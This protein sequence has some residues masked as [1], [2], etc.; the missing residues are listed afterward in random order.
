MTE[1]NTRDGDAERAA[2]LAGKIG[3]IVRRGEWAA[4]DDV[5]SLIRAALSDARDAALRDARAEIERLRE[6]LSAIAAGEHAQPEPAQR[7]DGE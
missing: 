4:F 7:E 3:F 2:E 6:G 5:V 1:D